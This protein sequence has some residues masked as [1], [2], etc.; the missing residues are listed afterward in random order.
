VPGKKHGSGT[1]ERWHGGFIHRTSA[2]FRPPIKLI[3]HIRRQNDLG[4]PSGYLAALP[5][6]G[7]EPD[8]A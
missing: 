8:G 4:W 5:L 6:D 1:G 7:D 2:C 3:P